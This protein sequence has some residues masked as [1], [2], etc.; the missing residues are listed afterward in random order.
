MIL[1]VARLL[2]VASLV[3]VA[4]AAEPP[5]KD[6]EDLRQKIGVLQH[7]IEANEANRSEAADALRESEKAISDANREIARLARL[8]QM[9]Q[10]EL[11]RAN[12]DV[13]KVRAQLNARRE[14][15][16]KL[17]LARYRNGQHEA[18]RLLLN[19]QDPNQI[20]RQLQYYRYIVN[21]QSKLST[22]L[23][24][25]LDTLNQ[26]SETLQQKNHELTQLSDEKK[27]QRAQ[28]Q[29]SQSNRQAVL[30]RIA[31]QIGE[32]QQEISKL[33]QDEQRLASLVDKLDRMIRERD[34]RE[35]RGKEK[36]ARDAAKAAKHAG[37][38][39]KAAANAPAAKAAE[40]DKDGAAETGEA[41]RNDIAQEVATPSG[42]VELKGKLRLPLRGEV[43]GKFGSAKVSGTIWK[44]V[45]IK[46]PAGLAVKAVG[47][48]R[49]VFADWLRG[50]GNLIIVDHGSG[51][52]SL[53]G[54]AE[55]LIRQVGDSV[56][57]GDDVATSGNSGGSSET[58]I[59]F[60]LRHLG[61]PI[62]PLAWTSR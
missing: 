12:A 2:L 42:F 55:S 15:I 43:K 23:A 52:L 61:N 24:A 49:V 19:K 44:G 10:S 53:Y 32:Q 45:F 54:A 29:A 3:S 16:R 58:G 11:S 25:Q 33:Q 28:L 39:S 40:K 36:Q 9:T 18:L 27:Q 4:L 41:A 60:E 5:A 59:Y 21:A 48:G 1:P 20:Q 37:K 46:A 62:D 22:R 47:A 26:L 34:A 30:K 57:T 13:L 50:F 17:L 14:Q 31:A 35:A 6:L 51:Y 38:D 8:Q 7:E 56:Q